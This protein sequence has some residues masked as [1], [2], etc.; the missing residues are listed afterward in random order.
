MARFDI[1]Q[2]DGDEGWLIIV[3]DCLD[4]DRE[5]IMYNVIVELGDVVEVKI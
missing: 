2:G 3:L 5:V 4:L 1:F